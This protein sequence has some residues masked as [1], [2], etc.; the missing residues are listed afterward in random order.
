MSYPKGTLV[1]V[2]HF[3]SVLYGKND[4]HREAVRLLEERLGPFRYESP[5]FLFDF[6]DY[7]ESEM[8][9]PLYRMFHVQGI[10][11][12]AEAMIPVKQAC[13]A[14]EEMLK[15]GNRRTVNLDPGYLDLFKLVLASEKFRGHKIY[16]GSGICADLTLLLGKKKVESFPWTFPDFR[17]DRY[18]SFLLEMRGVVQKLLRSQTDE[19]RNGKG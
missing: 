5:E 8:G 1:P 10:L 9:K 16:L 14:V 19:T 6:T 7:Y 12:S 18:Y 11:K 3:V 2:L 13:L 4:I 17:S 15:T